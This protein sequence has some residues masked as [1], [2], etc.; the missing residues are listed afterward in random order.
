[1]SLDFSLCQVREVEEVSL[2]ITHNLT[3]MAEALGV[4]QMLWRPEEIPG[5]KAKDMLEPLGKAIAE[6]SINPRKY[7]KY[8]APNGW[9]TI[10]HFLPWLKKVREACEEYPEATPRSDT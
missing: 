8:E 3:D 1:M 5:L 10:E 2:N 9:G 4:Y 6:L 7:K